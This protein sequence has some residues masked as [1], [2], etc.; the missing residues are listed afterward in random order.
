MFTPKG[1]EWR[2]REQLRTELSALDINHPIDMAEVCQRLSAHRELPIRLIAY[3]LEVP[4]PF[5]LWLRTTSADYIMYQQETTVLHQQHIIAHELGHLL[6]GHSSDDGDDAV[7]AELLPDVPPDL[8]RRALRRANYDTEQERDA[9]TVATL[10]L[11]RATV[12]G[13]VTSPGRSLRA[14][15]AQR[16]LGD[17]QD[18]L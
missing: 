3:P 12:V 4:G 2:L 14:R 17:R 11:E 15:R 1:R 6:A 13:S 7:W 18:W 10:L 8:L 16:S 9:E 5:G